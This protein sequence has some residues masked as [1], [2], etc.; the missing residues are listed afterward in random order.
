MNRDLILKFLNNQTTEKENQKVSRW[1]SDPK[2]EEEVSAILKSDW[3]QTNAAKPEGQFDQSAILNLLKSR[4]ADGREIAVRSGKGTV[5]NRPFLVRVAAVV[6]L[7]LGVGYFYYQLNT[8]PEIAISPI[9]MVEKTTA[10]GQR[11]I[12]RLR[13]GSQVMLHAESRITYGA[14]FG[15]R[16]R[17]V[18]L[19][20]EAFFEVAEDIER[21]FQ[22]R[23]AHTLTTA[24]GT[25]FNVMDYPGENQSRISL[26]TGK[27]KVLKT[28]QKQEAPLYL[29]PGEEA[30]VNSKNGSMARRKFDSKRVLS[31][32]RG[33]LYFD[34]TDLQETLKMLERWY[35]VDFEVLTNRDLSHLKG[36]G[37]FENQTLENILRVLS[38]S[39]DFSFEIQ[40][41][42]V[43][44]DFNQP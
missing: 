13:D 4:I 29:E 11:S 8:Q 15:E 37:E 6:L 36:T 21:P 12:V 39:M 20:G 28:G 43:I 19:E 35:D 33:V 41:R 14:D 3:E 32:T 30:V 34:D 9:E 2:N 42:E 23:T 44:V 27:V 10:K 17:E 22:V 26:A 1:L 5:R 40:G 24:L 25:S 38:Y 7:V 18:F 31:W 16:A